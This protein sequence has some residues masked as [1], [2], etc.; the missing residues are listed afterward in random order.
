MSDAAK[1][2]KPDGKAWGWGTALIV[3][4]ISVLAIAGY[5]SARNKRRDTRSDGPA[6][7]SFDR[8][9]CEHFTPWF[10]SWKLTVDRNGAAVLTSASTTRTMDLKDQI[11]KIEDVLGR[12]NALEIKGDIDDDVIAFDSSILE[13]TVES[14]PQ[15]SHVKLY[16]PWRDCDEVRRTLDIYVLVR[17][18][19]KERGL[20]DFRPDI[21]NWLAAHPGR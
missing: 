19:F 21:A 3:L 10:G 6:R 15:K 2:D 1:N 18:Q 8:L 9:V 14:G 11:P 13:L 7:Q 20:S 4:A 5:E 12:N 17:S 16:W